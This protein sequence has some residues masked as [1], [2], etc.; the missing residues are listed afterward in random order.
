MVSGEV[1]ASADQSIALD[2]IGSG[3]V[4]PPIDSGSV[5]PAISISASSVAAAAP[6]TFSHLISVKLAQGNFLFWRAQFLSLLN[7]HA[8]LGFVDGSHP[9]PPDTIA[10]PKPDGSVQSNPNPTNLSWKQQDQAILSAIL[11]SSKNEVAAMILFCTTSREAWQ[12]L[13]RS[14]SSQLSARSMQIRT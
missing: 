12:I 1:I 8:L 11:A 2:A 3:F 7:T 10:T 9:C 6:V 5:T 13:D 14:F 4:N